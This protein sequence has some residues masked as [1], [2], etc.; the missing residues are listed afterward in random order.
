MGIDLERFKTPEQ[1]SLDL[2][3]PDNLSDQ[4]SEQNEFPF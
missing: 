1:A 2:K 4:P 3:E